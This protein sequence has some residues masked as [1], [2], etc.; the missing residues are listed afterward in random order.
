M[1]GW[2][3]IRGGLHRFYADGE[4]V[5]MCER[6]AET[7]WWYATAWIHGEQSTFRA[8]SLKIAKRFAEDHLASA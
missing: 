4:I 6:G 7:G 5:A 1:T 3:C 2:R 8:A